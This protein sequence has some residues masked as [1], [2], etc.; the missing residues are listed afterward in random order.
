MPEDPRESFRSELEALGARHQLRALRTVRRLPGGAVELEG[1]RYLDLSSNDYLGLAGDAGLLASWW[2]GAGAPSIDE[3]GMSG[4]SSR[5]L[6]GSGPACEALER[7][8]GSL[9]GGRSALVFSSGYHANIGLLP[10]LGGKGDL[11]LCD[12]LNHASIIDG[13][14]LSG[15]EFRRYRHGDCD[16][17]EELLHGARGRHRRVL[18]VT[19]SVFSMDGDCADLPRLV[20]LKREHGALLIVDEAHA[21]GVFGARGLGL[22]E[23]QGVLDDVDVIVGTCGKALASAGAFVV[24][25]PLIRDYCVNAARSLIFTTAP[26]PAVLSWTLLTLRRLT[27]MAPERERLALLSAS[28]RAGLRERGCACG[29]ASQIVPILAGDNERA[30]RLAARLRDAGF[31]AFPIRPPSVPPGTA[32]VRLSLTAAMRPEQLSG[33]AAAAAA[34]AA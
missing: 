5:L 34:A 3:R 9:Y 28:L 6:T 32:R 12:K 10:A 29:G 30:V 13:L 24:T 22:A 15:A 11:F 4:S 19:E 2:A 17:L 33:L 27:A 16:H 14:R 1:R 18:I 7:E 26:P 8:L 25:D 21:L 23:Q 31:L 20:R